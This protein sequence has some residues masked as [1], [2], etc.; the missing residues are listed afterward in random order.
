MPEFEMPVVAAP[1]RPIALA[2]PAAAESAVEA[3]P[4]TPAA[5]RPPLVGW[6]KRW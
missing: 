3:P 2:E 5:A 6:R 4:P 1:P